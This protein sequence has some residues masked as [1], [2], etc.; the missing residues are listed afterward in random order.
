MHMQSERIRST[1][2]H[3]PL[4]RLSTELILIVLAKLALLALIGWYLSVHYPRA[5]TRPAAV[6]R[7]LA[8]APPTP[9][10]AKP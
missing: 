1:S 5:D 9:S 8:P 10:E 2:S 4:R 3:N 7:L 6:E